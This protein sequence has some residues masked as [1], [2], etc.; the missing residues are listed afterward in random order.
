MQPWSHIIY[1]AL[2][3]LLLSCGG[4]NSNR[5][6]DV[7]V[8][9]AG[10]GS[11]DTHLQD[12]LDQTGSPALAVFSMKDN[13]IVEL[14][15]VGL[16]STNDTIEVTKE[17][18]WHI[19]SITKSMTATL[20]G[21]IVDDGLLQ[22]D[23]TVQEIFPEWEGIILAMYSD[24][25]LRQLLSHTSGLEDDWSEPVYADFDPSLSGPDQRY[26]GIQLALSY[27]HQRTRGAHLYANLNYMIAGAMLEKVTAQDWRTLI[28]NRLFIPLVMDSAGFELPGT[29]GLLDQPKG[30]S[31]NYSGQYVENDFEHDLVFEPAGLVHLSLRSMANYADFHLRG[32]RG[33][34][35]DL[36]PETYAALY[37]PV[38]QTGYAFGW[39]ANE[40]RITHDGTN[41]HWYAQLEIDARKNTA[42]FAVTNGF[43]PNTYA[44]TSVTLA[45]RSLK[46]RL[47]AM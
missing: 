28:S 44:E 46:Q 41:G 8:G 15:A 47:D 5:S 11:L 29:Q 43:N 14:S 17:D 25:S 23:S 35:S 32:F 7:D 4:D 12:I 2:T 21:F 20:A 16:R 39:Y 13:Q 26:T 6:T 31:P 34:G 18:V 3:V 9:S 38:E 40:N 1:L 27:D 24:L 19:G 22:W 45:L 10:D 37:T 33:K 30:H 42:I 36:A